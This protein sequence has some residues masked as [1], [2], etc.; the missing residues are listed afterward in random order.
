MP[1]GRAGRVSELALVDKDIRGLTYPP[2]IK[3]HHTAP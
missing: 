3:L 2:G 1:T